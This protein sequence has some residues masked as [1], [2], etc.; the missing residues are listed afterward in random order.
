MKSLRANFLPVVLCL[1]LLSPRYAQAGAVEYIVNDVTSP[2]TTD[3]LTP[4]LIGTGLTLAL[5]ATKSEISHPV[6]ET[7]TRNRPLNRWAPLGDWTG[8]MYPNMIY[9]GGAL[10]SAAFGHERG[11][12][13]AEEMALASVYSGLVSSL[14]K[15]MVREGRPNNGADKKSFPSGHATTAFAFAGIV[16]AEHPIYFAIPAYILAT[17]TAYSRINDNKHYLHDVV[18]GATIGISYALGVYYNRKKRDEAKAAGKPASS[19]PMLALIPSPALDGGMF[20][21]MISF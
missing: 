8:K 14:L 16:G 13:R 21:A 19:A 7:I 2:V 17:N 3:A 4:F 1:A 6:Q 5:I 10:L 11:L 12:V 20:G 18:G 9:T 15:V